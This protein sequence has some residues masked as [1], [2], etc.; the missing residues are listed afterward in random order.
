MKH[1]TKIESII[2]KEHGF[3]V[4]EGYFDQLSLTILNKV[5]NTVENKAKIF[6][7]NRKFLGYAA[8]FI[9]F[10]I[11]LYIGYLHFNNK[12]TNYVVSPDDIAAYIESS[13]A[14]NENDITDVIEF[15]NINETQNLNIN[16]EEIIE[17]L[18]SENIDYYTIVNEMY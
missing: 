18:L 7:L 3:K 16:S 8:S 10:L 6:Y 12:A 2:N 4:P 17:Y 9:G 1:P 14:L 13:F 11:V 15:K 5:E